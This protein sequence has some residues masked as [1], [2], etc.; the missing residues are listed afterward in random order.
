LFL[1][2][3]VVDNL[4]ITFSITTLH[5]WGVSVLP[6]A[7]VEWLSKRMCIFFTGH[8]V[9]TFSTISRQRLWSATFIR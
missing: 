4:A 7:A 8:Y 5:M 2:F 9:L 3:P 6:V 1:G